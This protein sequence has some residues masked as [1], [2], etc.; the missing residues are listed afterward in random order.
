MKNLISTL[1]ALGLTAVFLSLGSCYY[2]KESDLYGTPVC[3]TS[4]ITWTNVIKPIIDQSCAYVGCHGGGTKSG[5]HDLT[6]Y[7]GVYEIAQS[8]ALLGAIQH[9]GNYTPMPYQG[10]QLSECTIAKIKIWVEQGA[11][12]N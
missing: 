10:A 12:Q 2:D 1:A 3:D 4:S 7:E 8:G 11:P 6:T 5:D 9:S